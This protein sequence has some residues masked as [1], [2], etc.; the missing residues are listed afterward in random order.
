MPEGPEVTIIVNG[1]N[2][3]LKDSYIIDIEF[4]NKSRYFKKKPY[5]YNNFISSLKDNNVKIKEINNKGKFIYWIF[6]NNYI[7]FQTFGLSGGWYMNEKKNTGCELIYKDPKTYEIKTLYYDDQRR[8][9]TFK[10]TN[11]IIDLNNKLSSIG[12]DMLN[13][14]NFNLNDF[15]MILKNKKYQHKLIVKLLTDQKIISGIGNYLK[16]EILYDARINPHRLIYSL[17][18]YEISKLY[19]SIKHCINESFKS[20]GTSIQNYSNIYDNPGDYAFKLNVYKKKKDPYG[21]HVKAEKIQKDSQ[22]TYWVPAI[23]K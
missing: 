22:T 15:I 7:I 16:S 17:T 9:G 19:K 14:K 12:P 11:S 1:L 3:L 4:N 8:F 6:S 2:K 20:G 23:Q 5:G 21:Y 10:F 18:N 13:D